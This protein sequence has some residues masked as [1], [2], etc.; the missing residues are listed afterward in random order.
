MA[1]WHPKGISTRTYPTTY[2]GKFYDTLEDA[3]TWT[4]KEPPKDKIKILEVDTDNFIS[5]P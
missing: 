2:N 4:P 1:P 5:L 3:M